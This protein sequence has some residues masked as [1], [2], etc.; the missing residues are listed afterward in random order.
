MSSSAGRAI[1]Y[2]LFGESHGHGIGA[3]L[4]GIPAGVEIDEALIRTDL[5]RR[6][7]GASRLSTKRS[8]DDA[9]EILS[10]MREGRTSGGPLAFLIRNADA[11]SSDYDPDLPRPSHAD[12]PATLKH[13]SAVDLRGGGRFS[14]RLTAPLV[15]AGAVARQILMRRGISA[16]GH[17]LS[18]A[19]VAD[20]A[21]D[22]SKGEGP[23]AALL[24]SFRREY[25]PLINEGVR[26]AMETRIERAKND[27]DSVGGAVEVAVIGLPA[28]LG[29][30]PFEG[31]ESALAQWIFAVPAV[32]ALEFGAGTAF[33]RM[34]GSEANDPIVL[35]GGKPAPGSNRAGGANG[36]I[37]NGNP[38]IFRATI[39]PTPSIAR[40]QRSVRLSSMA[41][42]E[43]IVK[44]RH[45]PCVVPRALPGLEA[46]ALL[47]L[48]DLIVQAEGV[49]WMR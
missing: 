47:S 45:D 7:P 19:D 37:A 16:G 41:E 20:Q 26:G 48:L 40:P 5:D 43:I 24:E 49:A 36:G 29:E 4:D 10:G 9:A 28:G 6:K 33:A 14:G 39:R 32:K 3:V 22:L 35:R 15:A 18:I 38:V 8:E 31:V 11:H 44:G 2:T 27:M 13:G 12:L 1:R 21:F 25:L 42:E 23:D 46:A 34:K 17:I 30:P